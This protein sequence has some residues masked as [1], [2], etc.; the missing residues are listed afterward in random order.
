MM[1]ATLRIPIERRNQE[2]GRME[3]AR[4]WAVA[5]RT[6]HTWV[7]EAVNTAAADGMTFSGPNQSG[8]LLCESSVNAMTIISI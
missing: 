8:V 5:D 7:N 2:K 1:S 6:V 4:L 3:Q